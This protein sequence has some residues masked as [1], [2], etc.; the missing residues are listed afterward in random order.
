MKEPVAYD[1]AV[2]LL[3]ADHK[4]VKKMFIDHAALCESNAPEAL[5][6]QLALDIC[7]ALTVH[8]E[9]EEEIFYP[10]VRAVIGDNALIDEALQQHAQAK[11]TIS[12]IE[13]MAA[14][15]KGQD[16]VVKQLG[17][18]IDLHVMQERELIFLKARQAAL[19]LRGMAVPLLRRKL[20]LKKHVSTTPAKE[21]A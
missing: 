4:A 12:S 14:S 16:A 5:K 10:Q 17:Q 9:I 11:E 6:R 3:D 19:D 13:A 8:A 18:L 2:D 21:H 1:D 20:Q 7:Q 15:H